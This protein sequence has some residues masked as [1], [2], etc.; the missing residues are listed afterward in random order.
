MFHNSGKPPKKYTKVNGIMKLNPAYKKWKEKENNKTTEPGLPATPATTLLQ[1]K[2]ALPVVSTMEDHEKLNSNLKMEIPFA[3]ATDATIEMLQDDDICES[4]GMNVDDMVDQLGD[5]LEKYEIPIGMTNK[6]MMLSEYASLEFI[7]DDSG[8]MRLDTEIVDK[9]T[10]KPLSRWKE[11]QIRL[12]DMIEIIAYVPFEQIG[13]EFL[14]RKD[15]LSIK[16]DGMTDTS[17]KSVIRSAYAQIDALFA[18]GP[19]GTTPALEKL[20]ESFARGSGKS[21]SRYFF[22]DGKPN[23][24]QTAINA[25]IQLLKN[26]SDPDQ[27]PVTLLSCTND[28]EAVEWMKDCEE[29]APYCSESDDFNDEAREVLL[30]QGAALPYSN[31]FH[32]ICQIVAAMCPDDLDAMDESIPFT[33][34]TLDNLLGYV[35]ND[36][37]YK[38]Y[39]DKY[40]E[41]QKKRPV[42]I[43]NRTNQPKKI[44]LLRK[45]TKWNQN[46]FRSTQGPAKG[47]PQVQAFKQSMYEQHMQ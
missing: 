28:D 9:M 40:E 30:D 26:R 1:P 4:A 7:I 11:A 35:S 39:F 19:T 34:F 45:N 3:E 21:I 6:L 24:G 5:M 18:V 12:K 47:I 14:N 33:K 8:S 13:I 29:I 2:E 25:I 42:L 46:E 20:Q 10:G 37:S 27:N 41:A 43:D 22:G 36:E 17:P 23:G 38:H 15:R 32:L 44:D 16:R 31:G